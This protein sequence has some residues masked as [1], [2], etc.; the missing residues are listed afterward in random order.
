VMSTQEI[1]TGLSETGYSNPEFDALFAEQATTLDAEK[2]KEIVWQMQQIV[3][4]DVVY[5]IPYYGQEVQA[6]RKDR[7][8]GWVID[9]GKIAL[10]D[11]SSLN[12]IEPVQ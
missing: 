3:F 11:P 5:V 4:D 7:F 9:Q 1:P 6:F 12:V 2:R 10:D 8:T